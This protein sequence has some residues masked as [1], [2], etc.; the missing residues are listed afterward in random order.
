VAGASNEVALRLYV[1]CGFASTRRIEI[2]EDVQSE[3]LVWAAS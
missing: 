2:H 3:V 1:R